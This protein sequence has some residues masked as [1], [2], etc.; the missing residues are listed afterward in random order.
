MEQKAQQP[1]PKEQRAKRI[2]ELLEAGKTKGILT[3]KEIMD[4]LEEL[5]LDQEQI[6]KIYDHIEALNIDV[7]EEVEVPA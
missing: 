4:A 6:E 3:Y 7:V 5:E 2:S 1:L